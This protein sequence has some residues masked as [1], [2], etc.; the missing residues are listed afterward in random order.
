[1]A[2][3]YRKEGGRLVWVRNPFTGAITYFTE[4]H[5]KQS[6]FQ[7]RAVAP[8]SQAPD[9]EAA[10]AAR[11]AELSGAAI[12]RSAPATKTRPPPRCCAWSRA[13]S[14]A[15]LPPLHPG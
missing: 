2:L 10:E 5:R 11:M 14:R 6:G 9:W 15:A 13:P 12:A 3:E 8:A 7:R 4:I 1:M